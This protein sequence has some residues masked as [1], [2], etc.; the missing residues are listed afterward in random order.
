MLPQQPRWYRPFLSLPSKQVIIGCVGLLSLLIAVIWG[1]FALAGSPEPRAASEDEMRELTDVYRRYERTFFDAMVS[2]N[3]A[4]LSEILYN[5]PTVELR[6]ELVELSERYRDTVNEVLQGTAA[7]VPVGH[8]AGFLSA[9]IAYIANM[10]YGIEAWEQEQEKAQQESREAS[11]VHLP[12]G[13]TPFQ[14]PDPSSWVPDVPVQL[15][16]VKV[17]GNHATA[18]IVFVKSELLAD[19]LDRPDPYMQHYTFTKVDSQ[20]YISNIWSEGN[21]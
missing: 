2:G 10:N 21:P 1:S 5:D 13:A 9:Q 19:Y 3:P 18:D 7:N 14:R 12:P 4:H 20:W 6:S 16:N 8:E 11:P 15:L 17:G